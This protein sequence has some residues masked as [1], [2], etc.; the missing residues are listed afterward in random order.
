MTRYDAGAGPAR[1]ILQTSSS[2]GEFSHSRRTPAAELNPW[3]LHYWIV[4]WDLAPGQ[5]RTVETLPHPNVQLVFSTE[6]DSALVHGVHPKRFVRELQGRTRVFGVKFRAGG[7]FPFLQAPISSL[8]G[9]TLPAAQVFGEDIEKLHPILTGDCEEQQRVNRANDFF[10]RR[11]PRSDENAL[12]AAKL[13]ELIL[14]SP[15]LRS[16]AEL[17]TCSGLSARSL[18]RLFQQYVGVSPKWVICRYRLHELVERL[19]LGEQLDW[20]TLAVELGYFDQSHLIRDFRTM[21]GQSPAR[22]RLSI[23]AQ[24]N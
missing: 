9:K 17:S 24:S 3:I 22:F 21:T 13:V 12:S 18:Q 20:A 7:F 16:V 2:L 10:C 6:D 23:T 1:G 14:T 8:R 4:E 5:A 11:M 15:D 19:N